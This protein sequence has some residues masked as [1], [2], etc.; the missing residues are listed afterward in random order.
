[1]DDTLAFH[2][3][4]GTRF[5]EFMGAFRGVVCT[6]GFEPVCEAAYLDKPVMMVPVENHVE[7][8][9]NAIDAEQ[10][11]FGVKAD[12]FDLNRLLEFERTPANEAFRGWVARAPDMF[13]D[14]L[15][16]AAGRKEP[17]VPAA[18]PAA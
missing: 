1:M 18:V 10:V 11:G 5:L 15:Q 9:M 8:A 4:H 2:R 7:Q 17:P 6:A 3:L 16:R 13:L 12:R 14:L